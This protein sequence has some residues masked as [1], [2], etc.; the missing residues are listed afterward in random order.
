[1]SWIISLSALSAILVLALLIALDGC[2]LQPVRA[3][4]QSKRAG[5]NGQA[6]RPIQSSR[7]QPGR[8]TFSMF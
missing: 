3:L 7:T 5:A 4:R 8:Q 1:M 2:K 6:G